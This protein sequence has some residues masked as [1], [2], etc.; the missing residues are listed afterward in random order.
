VPQ[1]PEAYLESTEKIAFSAVVLLLALAITLVARS[2][3]KRRIKD[4]AHLST[5]YMLIRNTVLIIGLGAVVAIWL[6]FG[7]SFTVAVGIIGAGIAFASQAVIGSFAGYLNIVTG[8]LFH[9]GDR[10]RIGDVMGDVLDISLLRTT[11][12]EIGEWAKLDQYT[13]RVVAVAN[14]VVFSDP[15]YN[16]TQHWHYLWDELAIPITYPSDWRRAAEIM[17]QHGQQY[18]AQHQEQAQAALHHMRKRYPALHDAP[19][20]PALYITMTDNWIEMTLRYIV[21]ARHRRTVQAQLHRDL[22][23]HFEAEPAITVASETFEI[24][25]LPPLKDRVGREQNGRGAGM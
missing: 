14:S 1:I 2:L 13:G 6:E 23:E 15:V 11:V 17:L 12:M 9:I 21:D 5:V 25:G 18:S 24:V 3:L 7:S 10:I 4:P 22:L 16:Y 20:E 8:N 19:V